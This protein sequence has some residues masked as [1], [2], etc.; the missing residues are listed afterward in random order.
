MACVHNE[1]KT[2]ADGELAIGC[3]DSN[4]M[5]F[6]RCEYVTF[7]S[8]LATLAYAKALAC[9]E[10]HPHSLKSVHINANH[11]NNPCCLHTIYQTDDF[12]RAMFMPP[13]RV[14]SE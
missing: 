12:M 14:K 3:V 10:A 6:G 1:N 4:N 9:S 2:G 8:I 5:R 7:S 11:N 13:D